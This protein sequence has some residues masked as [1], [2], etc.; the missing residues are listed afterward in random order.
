M[1]KQNEKSNVSAI[2]I[3]VDKSAWITRDGNVGDQ[4]KYNNLSNSSLDRL[5]Q[6]SRKYKTTFNYAGSHKRPAICISRKESS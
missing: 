5:S 2:W 4:N 1:P 3:Y 6:L